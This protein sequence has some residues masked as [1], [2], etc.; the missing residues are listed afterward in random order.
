MI[1]VQLRILYIEHLLKV[2]IIYYCSLA[3]IVHRQ[4]LPEFSNQENLFQIFKSKKHS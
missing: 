4:N 2:L 3:K 1:F